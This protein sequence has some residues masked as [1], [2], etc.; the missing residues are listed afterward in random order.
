M[1]A[2]WTLSHLETIAH[3][4][5]LQTMRTFLARIQSNA[6]TI[7]SLAILTIIIMTTH[8]E[9]TKECARRKRNE[10][11]SRMVLWLTTRVKCVASEVER[12]IGSLKT[13]KRK[14]P[15][16]IR[17]RHPRSQRLPKWMRLYIA[18]VVAL[19]TESQDRYVQESGPFDTDAKLIGIDNRCSGCIS[20][21]RADFKG[22][23]SESQRSIKGFGGTRHF[24]VWTG[25]LSWSWD[26]DNGMSHEFIIPNSYYIPEGKVR[27][28]SPQHWA[29]TRRG[30]DKRGGAGEVTNGTTTTLFWDGSKKRRTVMLD[31]DGSNVATFPMSPG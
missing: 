4:I 15:R 23:L 22:S 10:K 28:L 1:I 11:P 17:A 30:T 29:Q 21:E 7:I 27:L 2:I 16:T 14:Y 20:F 26:D 8:D 24:R 9:P 6:K 31:R 25:T 18:S 5:A 12:F 13:R 19:Q 3:A